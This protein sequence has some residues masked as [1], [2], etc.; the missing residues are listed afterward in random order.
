MS[1]R[2]SATGLV[3]RKLKRF[4]T[5]GWTLLSCLVIGSHPVVAADL[6]EVPVGL[7]GSW[8]VYVL[9]SW[10]V[11]LMKEIA[12][13]QASATSGWVGVVV[14]HGDTLAVR[15]EEPGSR[16]PAIALNDA[17]PV[18]GEVGLYS[19]RELARGSAPAR[20]YLHHLQR[21]LQARLDTCA[22]SWPEGGPSLFDSVQR[23]SRTR[24][25]S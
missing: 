10:N 22:W 25:I 23:F 21:A 2:T 12:G 14:A 4:K 9:E 8:S 16:K 3:P 5:A 24:S 6:P 19:L 15:D 17:R 11:P 13:V 20:E 7:D 1:S 18:Q